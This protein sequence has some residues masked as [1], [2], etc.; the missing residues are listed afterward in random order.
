MLATAGA[1]PEGPGWAYELKW[2]GVRVLADRS[3]DRLR[4]QSRSERDITMTYP[5]L[6]GLEAAC[7]DMLLD[8]EVVAF[9]DGR[10]TF[11]ALQPRMHVRDA[12]KARALQKTIPVTY[13]IFDILRLYGVD[14]TG[15]PY[16]ERRETL[17]RLDLDV[18]HCL[19]PPVFDD[20]PATVA[21][22]RAQN[23][24]G[25]VAKALSSRYFPGARSP[26]W[27]K[28]RTSH[29]QEFVVCG[30]Q[31]GAGGR[32]NQVGSLVLGYYDG[33]ALRYAG[34]VGTGFT[35]PMLR[36]VQ[37]KLEPL[38]RDDSPFDEELPAPDRKDVLWCDPEVVVMVEF[39]EWT[40]GGRLRFPSFQGVRDDKD[41][42]EVVRE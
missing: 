1:L 29:R 21:A 20:G 6:G 30:W 24:E 16:S 3:P 40:P 27:I 9:V 35:A 19:V 28:V 8:G 18:P 12:R 31:R 2:D 33:D 22:S 38:R 13:L 4:L 15:R 11:T 41:P 25:V 5:E 26:Q 7:P 42:R 34:Q 39:L 32:T 14:L 36:T 23:L 17:E 10:P 37:E